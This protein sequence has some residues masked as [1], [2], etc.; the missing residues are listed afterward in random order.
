MQEITDG[1][2]YQNAYAGV[3]LGAVILP[4]GTLLIDS[5]LIPDEA[6]SWK[7]I[8]LTQSIGTHRLLVNLDGHIDRTVGNRYMDFTTLAQ[9]EV[10]RAYENRSAVFKG[11]TYDTG[12]E[13][14]KYPEIIGSRW[15]QPNITF[16]DHLQLHW[17]PDEIHLDH[18]PGPT[19]GAIWV[20]IPSKKIV[21]IG[22]AVLEDQPPFLADADIPAWL[23][24][25]NLLRSK[26]YNRYAIISGRSGSIKVEAIR[27]QYELLKS[28]LGRLETLAQ[29]DMTPEGT[30]KLIPALLSKFKVPPKYGD[31]FSQRLRYGLHHYYINHYNLSTI[32]QEE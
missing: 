9:T 21:F 10:S 2:Y 4:G 20:E 27:D 24:T 17:G 11:Q 26:K 15:T 30:Q 25:L 31:F 7:S 12:S 6:R 3:T 23:E 1:I 16:E 22:D 19:P 28:I 18:H 8:L 14:E 13:W 29:R 32:S 5:P